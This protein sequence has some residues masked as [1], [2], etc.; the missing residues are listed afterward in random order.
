MRDGM[1]PDVG[2]GEQMGELGQSPE[3]IKAAL[4][5]TTFTPDQKALIQRIAQSDR[6]CDVVRSDGSRQKGYLLGIVDGKVGVSVIDPESGQVIIKDPR[7]TTFESWQKGSPL[8][9]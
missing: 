7:L 1:S 3:A 5:M 9:N 4:E 2:M 8:V 6:S